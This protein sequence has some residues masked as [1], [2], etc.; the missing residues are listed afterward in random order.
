MGCM[1]LVMG[2]DD[3]EKGEGGRRRSIRLSGG[4]HV[5]V[6]EVG[7]IG[8]VEGSTPT[9]RSTIDGRR[10]LRLCSPS[11]AAAANYTYRKK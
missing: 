1:H 5:V 4:V 9:T 11:R 10:S 6:C 8:C 7:R 2:A 3:L